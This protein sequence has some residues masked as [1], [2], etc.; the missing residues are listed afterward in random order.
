MSKD[1]RP[2]KAVGPP[3]RATDSQEEEDTGVH[4]R[5]GSAASPSQHLFG[6][7]TQEA[8]E[9]F[10][11]V[12]PRSGRI[13]LVGGGVSSM[14]GWR[15]DELVRRSFVDGVEPRH[16]E[17]V[18]KALEV[19]ARTAG[20]R[21]TVRYRRQHKNGGF[22]E[23]SSVLVNRTDDEL[24]AG[25]VVTTS[26]VST[27]ARASIPPA[28]DEGPTD[29]QSFVDRLSRVLSR[30]DAKLSVL[31]IDVTNHRHVAAALGPAEAERLLAA[32]MRR[33]KEALRP[34]D[35][36][37]KVGP[38]E[39]AVL[40]EGNEEE[41]SVRRIADQ[42]YSKLRQ[43]FRIGAQEVVASVALGFATTV[44]PYEDAEALLTDAEAAA[45]R[46]RGSR[47]R[48][49]RTTMRSD[50]R[51][52]IQ[53]A[54]ALPRAFQRSE[55]QTRYQP[56]IRLD[57]GHVVGFEALCRWMHP[58]HGMISPGE[59]IPLAEQL[60]WIVAL[61]RW[62]IQESTRQTASWQAPSVGPP[63]LSVNL[64]ARHLDEP[65]LAATVATALSSSG[66]SPDRLHL[67]ITETALADD[68]RSSVDA[69]RSL[70]YLGVSLAIDDF[71]TG[72]ASFGQ[73]ADLPVDSLK[74]DRSFLQKIEEDHGHSV[75]HGIVD[76]G[77][78]LGLS[79]VAEGVETENQQRLLQKM[80]CD[81]AQGF[82][83]A[84]PVD[85]AE[86]KRLLSQR[87]G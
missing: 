15:A 17:E 34:G 35:V 36:V 42:L 40:L 9:W 77:H 16:R 81:F 29:R 19:A 48:G 24:V 82:Y 65:N 76:M 44:R 51:R 10:A 57:D 33:L 58:E 2:T 5:G 4:A 26:A 41:A 86:A 50:Y 62:M 21:T 72:Y 39:L 25:I 46:G 56:V 18:A 75:V 8:T 83:Y 64:S 71:G 60:D 69:L 45:Q 37:C 61:D 70:Q 54:A 63:W 43:S 32:L 52:R 20:S 23:V 31:A 28:L 53:L 3:R 30:P 59:F 14:L 49:F 85:G 13:R 78:E 73:L 55:L 79:I 7:L 74:I 67:E 12:S 84:K 80:G 68:Q 38:H 1:E 11:V 6:V 47:P 27:K 87:F 22:V 66:L